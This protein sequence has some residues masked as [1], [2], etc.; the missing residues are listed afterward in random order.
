MEGAIKSS[1]RTIAGMPI[2]ISTTQRKWQAL[3]KSIAFYAVTNKSCVG[4][5]KEKENQLHSWSC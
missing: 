2:I 1:V 3:K 4:S 5:Q